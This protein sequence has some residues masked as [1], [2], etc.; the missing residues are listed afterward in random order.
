MSD[1]TDDFFEGKRP[2][3]IIKDQVLHNYNYLD[4]ARV[5]NSICGNSSH[6]LPSNKRPP[7]FGVRPPI[8][9][10]RRRHAL[11]GSDPADHVPNL[12]CRDDSHDRS[13]RR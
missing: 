10:E 1:I 8:V 5:T 6:V 4:I 12:D 7:A 11:S 13:H 2:W 3:S 9:C